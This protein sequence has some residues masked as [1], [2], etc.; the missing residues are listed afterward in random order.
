VPSSV[1]RADTETG[2][3]VSHVAYGGLSGIQHV[4]SRLVAE[5][6]AQGLRSEVYLYQ[7]GALTEGFEDEYPGASAVYEY[8]KSRRVDF[9]RLL[10]L[11]RQLHRSQPGI[12][13]FHSLDAA[14]V[15]RLRYLFLRSRSRAMV[16][17][18]APSDELPLSY[19]ILSW[20]VLFLYPATVRV[21]PNS[22]PRP[23]SLPAR[24]GAT[25]VF[26]V[27]NGVSLPVVSPRYRRQDDLAI[28]GAVRMR[29]GVRE[30]INIGMGGRMTAVK[31]FSTIMA[32]AD[33]LDPTEVGPVRIVFAG[34]GPERS[35]LEA[36]AR[37]LGLP[38]EFTGQ[39]PLS[40]MPDFYASLDIYV[41]SSWSESDVST[42]ILQAFSHGVCVVA[43]ASPG[44]RDVLAKFDK[45][46]V[47][48]FT[49]GDAA[50]LATVLR[51]L[52]CQPLVRAEMARQGQR[53]VEEN[54]SAR[55]MA[56]TYL[57]IMGLVAPEH[58]WLQDSSR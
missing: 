10:R 23:C 54:Y 27:P 52:A 45:Q 33:L 11:L 21:G 38:V 12:V 57:R 58:A 2:V 49:P 47:R 14:V 55:A 39:L 18:H 46:F 35:R 4:V 6:A 36:E 20:L 42:S 9:R 17:Q 31:D 32:A 13:V 16:V 24:L 25:R 15:Y 5:F 19:R 26:D 43:S 56:R 8:Q 28:N 3:D 44:I 7:R 37:Y 50:A 51:G 40:A 30:P 53:F 22:F 29:G 41:Q 48:L 1:K 34:D